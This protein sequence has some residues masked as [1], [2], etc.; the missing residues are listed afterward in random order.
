MAHKVPIVNYNHDLKG[1]MQEICDEL[2][3]QGVLKIPQQHNILV[4]SVCPS[5][6]KRKRRAADK[7]KHLLTKDDVRLLINFVPVNNLIK[8]I[9]TPMVTTDDLYIKLG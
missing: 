3:T 5:F 9:P 4:Q 7:P 2:T 8:N 1:V 6:L